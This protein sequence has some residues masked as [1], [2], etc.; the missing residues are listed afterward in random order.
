MEILISAEQIQKRIAELA[1]EINAAYARHPITIIGVLTGSLI[2][3]ADLVRQLEL[4]I[5]IGLLQ[6]SS[7]RGAATTPGELQ[8]STAMVPPLKGRHVLIL[9]DIFDTGQTLASLTEHLREKEPLSLR[10][11]VLLRKIGR[12]RIAFTP[13]YIGFDIPDV[14]VVGY[15][16]DFND[17]YR[18]LPHV[19]ILA[20]ATA[21]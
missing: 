14:F 12:Q 11:A 8:L 16:M 3:L 18:N 15:G 20:D 1:H 4:P 13:D 21:P 6:A 19:A 5:Q 10:V 9:D 2:F 17:E 7:Y